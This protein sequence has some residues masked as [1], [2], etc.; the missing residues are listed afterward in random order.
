MFKKLFGS[1]NDAAKKTQEVALDP[2]QVMG[3]LDDQIE[4]VQKRS[5]VVENQI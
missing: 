1:S 4:Q 2:H 5:K 3:R